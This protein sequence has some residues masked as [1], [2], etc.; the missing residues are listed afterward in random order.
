MVKEYRTKKQESELSNSGK[1]KVHS[2][3]DS[4]SEM[5]PKLKAVSARTESDITLSF[6]KIRGIPSLSASGNCGGGGGS[7]GSC[8]SCGYYGKS[9]IR[10]TPIIVEN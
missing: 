9:P 4:E 8:G 5:T 2:S 6:L 1:S 3:G 7:C 10:H